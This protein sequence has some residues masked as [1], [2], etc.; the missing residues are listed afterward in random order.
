MKA[1]VHKEIALTLSLSG[2]E[3]KNLIQ[4]LGLSSPTKPEQI[5]LKRN[6]LNLLNDSLYKAD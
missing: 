3:A 5:E 2:E 1:V 4:V 6:L